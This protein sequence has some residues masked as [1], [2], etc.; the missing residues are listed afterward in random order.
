MSKSIS[1]ETSDAASSAR[2]EE[3]GARTSRSGESVSEKGKDPS[4]TPQ[5]DRLASLTILL[6]GLVLKNM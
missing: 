1:T 3:V 2:S 5:P 6:W 4:L